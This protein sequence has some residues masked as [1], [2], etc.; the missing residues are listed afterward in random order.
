MR[1]KRHYISV[2]FFIAVCLISGYFGFGIQHVPDYSNTPRNNVP[3]DFKWRIED[4]Y[5]SVDAWRADKEEFKKM[6]P[7]LFKLSKGWTSE[8][9]SMFR[10][11][12]FRDKV[13][14]KGYKLFSYASNRSN[15]D[16]GNSVFQKMKGELN[17]IFVGLSSRLSFL[18]SD[19][20]KLGRRKFEEFL[21][22]EP[23]LNNY[24]F[25]VEEVLRMSPHILP[26]EQ[27]RI[28]SLTGL[29]SGVPGKASNILN[30][31]E[32][33]NEK[34]TFSDG[35]SVVLNY[36]NYALYRRSKDSDDRSLAMRTYW[37]NHKKFEKTFS[38]LLDGAIKQHLFN[39][40]VGK[41]KNT[42]EAALYP[43]SIKTDVY[44]NL[45][46]N[47]RKNLSPLHRY[48][49]LKKDL[50]K[51]K[52][53]RYD[54][55]YASSV[56]KVEKTYTFNEAKKLVLTAMKPLGKE[57]GEALK[58]A[59]E[60]K[61][62]DIYP[63]RG[64]QS[65]AYSGGVYGVHPYVKLNFAGYYDN[66]S[67]LAHE[68]GH[69][70]HSW[71]S[72]KN[73]SFS[74]SHY[75]TFLA[76]IASTFNENMLMSYLLKHEKSDMFKLFL[77]DEYLERIRGTLYRQTLFSE[78][79]LEMHKR[80]EKGGMLTADWLDK[81]Y[82]KLTRFYYG[83]D[84][85]VVKVDDFISNEWAGIPHFYYN[86]YVYT[87]STG[88]IASMALAQKVAEGKDSGMNR[89]RYIEFLSAGGS[90]PPLEILKRA[91]VDMTSPGPYTLAFKRLD[92]LV[93]EMVRV[94]ERLRKSGRL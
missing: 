83:N 94:V 93:S 12:Q 6:I 79:E 40:R 53:F 13:Y 34:V 66:V 84:K 11:L 39:A 7:E 27:Q 16:M 24:S 70:M 78:F 61:W 52:E 32:I 92:Y 56:P 81:E 4:I 1:L 58:K 21:K 68:L 62:I 42:L 38:V 69:A 22:T 14:I 54:D 26:P 37:K 29:F 47:V 36:A 85:S 60:E 31:V 86:Y 35:K 65:G 64:K 74:N 33:P 76:E 19:I 50:L 9:G 15:M 57:Y 3:K 10:F 8:A 88:I 71:F 91:G 44:T 30:N 63:N 43:N 90:R 46:A 51:L 55:I 49:K 17:T 77:L 25:E 5:P 28:V 45:I 80:V 82:L 89:K 23:G 18:D 73:Q 67:T 2:I 72:S 48:L 20:M 87:Y 59:F 41:Y 75:A